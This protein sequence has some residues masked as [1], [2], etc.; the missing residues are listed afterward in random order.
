MLYN[1]RVGTDLKKQFGRH[2][3]AEILQRGDRANGR[4]V[5]GRR[6]KI[7]AAA[8]C[9][10]LSRAGAETPTVASVKQQQH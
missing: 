9:W 4:D 5:D 6:A 1:Q 10:V 8:G 3:S 7:A 2:R